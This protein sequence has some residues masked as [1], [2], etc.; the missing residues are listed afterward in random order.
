[1]S[2][3]IIGNL[4]VTSGLTVNNKNALQSVNSTIKSDING[5]LIIDGNVKDE[6]LDMFSQFPVSNVGDL[7]FLPLGVSGSYEGATNNFEQ[8]SYPMQLE[9]DG[10][11]VFLRPG[12]NGSSQGYYYAYIN[13]ALSTLNM[14]P[15][16]TNKVYRP[17][18]IPA[19]TFVKSFVTTDNNIFMGYLNDGRTFF[20]FPNGTMD[21]AKH[22][23]FV[24]AA[25][26][27]PHYVC[28]GKTYVYFITSTNTDEGDLN[29]TTPFGFSFAR[30]LLSDLKAGNI[31]SYEIMTNW[32]S[33]GVYGTTS[34]NTNIVM[35]KKL[36][37]PNV[38]NEPFCQ[39]NGSFQ[40]ILIFHQFVR[41]SIWAAEDPSTGL[42][43]VFVQNF[44]F[45]ELPLVSNTVRWAFNF[46][47]NTT[48][49]TAVADNDSRGHIVATNT[50]PT[51]I[52][53]SNPNLSFIM[54]NITGTNETYRGAFS[55][56]TLPD[57]VVFATDSTHTINPFYTIGRGQINNFTTLYNSYMRSTRTISNRV[58]VESKPYYGSA[59]GQTFM[60]IQPFPNNSIVLNAYGNNNGITTRGQIFSRYGASGYTY[61]SVNYGSLNGF[62]PAQQRQFVGSNLRQ[63]ISVID[64]A[65]N[66]TVYGTSFFEGGR[67]NN[68]YTCSDTNLTGTG[69]QSISSTTLL[70]LK[71]DSLILQFGANWADSISSSK[72]ILYSIPSSVM[73]SYAAILLRYT[74]NKIGILIVEVSTTITG[75]IITSCNINRIV[76]SFVDDILS[77]IDVTDAGGIGMYQQGITIYEGSDLYFMSIG[78]P[79][80]IGTVGQTR[81]YNV[82]CAI[83]KNT[84]KIIQSKSVYDFTLSYIFSGQ[85]AR[86]I[87]GAIPSLGFGAFDDS[88][89]DI[90]TKLTFVPVGNTMAQY[91]AWNTNVSRQ[92]IISQDVY[93]GFIVYFTQPTPVFISGKY[94]LLP[95]QS[96]LLND[97]KANPANTT[98]YLY[99][100]MLNGNAQYQI[101]TTEL[102]ESYECIYLGTIVT[103][104][105][106]IA[107]I[108]VSKVARIDTYRPSQTQIGSAFPVSDNSATTN[109]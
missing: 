67:L 74:N 34:T 18:F 5:N 65:K 105:T 6:V 47:I 2:H 45:A 66:V 88:V 104:G 77:N 103:D 80:Y 26:A 39:Y 91:D 41:G 25:M 7:G 37:D 8:Y 95:I 22:T 94:Q 55:V 76:N 28:V 100:N 102:A 84:K 79:F 69:E 3:K 33:T 35:A 78:M 32:T 29:D 52:T 97:I 60:G 72:I 70:K 24:R 86:L 1:M 68:F 50:N 83:D 9:D 4:E 15:I 21:D 75:T 61:Q 49:K 38:A 64:A 20:S 36:A 81:G 59:V 82:R 13:N 101:S 44:I 85:Q 19:G 87:F 46:V 58:S 40:R 98:F 57:G 11:L 62:A 89:N 42:I 107:T 93:T 90:Q 106:K 10:T 53:L 92:V 109:W 73:D 43:R 31:N 99:V 30:V 51:T 63:L 56:L 17:S 48:A 96:I 71:T 108:N 12:T 16:V 54:Q 27:L 14:N 23:G